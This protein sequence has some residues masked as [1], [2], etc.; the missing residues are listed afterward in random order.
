MHTI[1]KLA[2]ALSLT[3]A[4]PA[5][6]AAP[7]TTRTHSQRVYNPDEAVDLVSDPLT[8]Y[9]HS[10][11][12]SP[13][14]CPFAASGN[15]TLVNGRCRFNKPGSPGHGTEFVAWTAFKHTVDPDIGYCNMNIMLDYTIGTGTGFVSNVMFYSNNGGVTWDYAAPSSSGSNWSGGWLYWYLGIGQLS[16]FR[17]IV[18]RRHLTTGFNSRLL[19]WH[20]LWV[21]ADPCS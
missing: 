16:D 8:D 9:A 7:V 18:G 3:C 21:S 5:W 13:A 1:S 10:D 6:A 15:F 2:L 4:A 12:P 19:R 11:G 20:E 14:V 17:V